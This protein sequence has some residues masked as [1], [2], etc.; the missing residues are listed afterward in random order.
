M[1]KLRIL[2]KLG[3]TTVQWDTTRGAEEA[4]REAERIFRQEIAAGSTAFRVSAA[5]PGERIVSFDPHAE[6]IVI[7]PRVAGG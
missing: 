4:V 3:D 5:A 6:Q 2:S 7:V 1:G